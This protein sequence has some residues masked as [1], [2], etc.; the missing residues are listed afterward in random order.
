MRGRIKKMDQPLF[1]FVDEGILFDNKKACKLWR[2]YRLA[3][4]TA[5]ADTFF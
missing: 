1:L 2:H 4:L 3:A 5:G